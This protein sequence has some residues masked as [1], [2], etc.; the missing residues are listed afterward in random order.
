MPITTDTKAMR[1]TLKRL[2][3]DA[4]ASMDN[5]GQCTVQVA[6]LATLLAAYKI[7]LNKNRSLSKPHNQLSDA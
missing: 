1:E 5:Q 4:T 3:D 2:N 7:E 6:D